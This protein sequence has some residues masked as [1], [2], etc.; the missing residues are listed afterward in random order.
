VKSVATPTDP[1]LWKVANYRRFLQARREKLA[2][3]MNAFIDKKAG[4]G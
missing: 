1:E 3:C 2:V 4:I